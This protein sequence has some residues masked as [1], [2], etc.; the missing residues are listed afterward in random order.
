MTKKRSLHIWTS[1]DENK[2]QYCDVP[3]NFAY[4]IWM[5]YLVFGP[6]I[7]KWKACSFFR[8]VQTSYGRFCIYVGSLYGSYLSDKNKK[9][10]RA[11][12]PW[13]GWCCLVLTV[14]VICEGEHSER[15]IYRNQP[16]RCCTGGLYTKSRLPLHLP[17]ARSQPKPVQSETTKSHQ[18]YD[19]MEPYFSMTL[20]RQPT[21]VHTNTS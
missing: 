1:S 8:F 19:A 12:F 3:L 7:H 15:P 5:F 18:R 9:N 20:L 2:W 6:R 4:S 10:K 16:L 17:Q 11:G 13:N 21:I 14:S